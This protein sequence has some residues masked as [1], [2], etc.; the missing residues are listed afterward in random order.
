M[1]SGPE[2]ETIREVN[3]ERREEDNGALLD[4]ITKVVTIF[5]LTLPW[6]RCQAI[7]QADDRGRVPSASRLGF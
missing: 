7:K 3:E 4:D 1:Y 2:L 6:S 5:G